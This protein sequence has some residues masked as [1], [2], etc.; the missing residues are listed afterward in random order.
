MSTQDNPSLNKI[1]TSIDNLKD[2][3]KI[4]QYLLEY[5]K[6]NEDLDKILELENEITEINSLLKDLETVQNDPIWSNKSFCT[7]FEE[8]SK[9]GN[10]ILHGWSKND[11]TPLTP[12]INQP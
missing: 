6:Q 8:F 4:N 10:T 3:L 11:D 2:R 7:D 9:G 12:M 5:Y 1:L